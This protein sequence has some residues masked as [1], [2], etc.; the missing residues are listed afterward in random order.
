MFLATRVLLMCFVYFFPQLN[1]EIL[2]IFF[3]HTCSKHSN[4]I[5]FSHPFDFLALPICNGLKE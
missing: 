5:F 4:A 2:Y 1:I 3:W